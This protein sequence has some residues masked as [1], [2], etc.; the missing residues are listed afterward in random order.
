MKFKTLFLSASLMAAAAVFSFCSKETN[1]TDPVPVANTEEANSRGIC[2]AFVEVINSDATVCG[3]QTNAVNCSPGIFGSD[4]IALNGTKSYILNT[5]A[6]MIF[7]GSAAAGTVKVTTA[8]GTFTY[9]PF[10]AMANGQIIVNIDNF[11]NQ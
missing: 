7:T 4:F 1:A 8:N 3:S 9:G 2:K 5:P 11:C 10:G 6:T